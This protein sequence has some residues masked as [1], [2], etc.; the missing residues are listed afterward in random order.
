LSFSQPEAK[1]GAR[2]LREPPIEAATKDFA[3]KTHALDNRWLLS[4]QR[5]QKPPAIFGR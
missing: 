1:Q 5:A 2:I 3:A 4:R